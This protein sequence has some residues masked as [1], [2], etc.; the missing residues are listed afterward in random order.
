MKQPE[1]IRSGGIEI[2][3]LDF[4]GLRKKEE[5][6]AQMDVYG[7]YIQKQP[8]RSLHTLTNLEN[9]YFNTEVYNKLTSYV[10]ANNPYVKESAVIGLKGMMQIF[11][12]G[13]VKIT[14]RNVKVCNTKS[15]AVSA[16][17]KHLAEAV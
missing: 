12:K 7:N 3:Y 5:V 10:N 8:L 14:G 4:S 6:L 2:I 11:Y 1:I 13:F 15:E 17:S 9:M 16:L